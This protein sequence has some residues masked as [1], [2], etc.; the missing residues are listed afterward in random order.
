MGYIFID[1][2]FSVCLIN[3]HIV[4]T[5]LI[6]NLISLLFFTFLRPFITLLKLFHYHAYCP[7]HLWY[8]SFCLCSPHACHPHLHPTVIPSPSAS[9][10]YLVYPVALP[11]LLFPLTPLPHSRSPRATSCYLSLCWLSC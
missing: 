8:H 9:P 1:V 4:A 11:P 2:A 5:Y 10:Y 6:F 7:L 3:L